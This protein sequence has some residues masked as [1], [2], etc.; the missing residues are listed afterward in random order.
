M[1]SYPIEMHRVQRLDELKVADHAETV[2]RANLP[3]YFLQTVD[4]MVEDLMASAPESPAT[5]T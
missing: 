3:W 1:E 2:G 5:L 4:V